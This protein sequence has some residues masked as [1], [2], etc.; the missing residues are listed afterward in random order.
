VS[1]LSNRWTEEVPAQT[2]DDVSLPTSELDGRELPRGPAEPES[3]RIGGTIDGVHRIRGV[4]G[5]G[6]MGTVYLAH[7]EQLQRDVAVKLIHENELAD[8]PVVERFLAE[9][10]AM[11]RVQ[12]PNVVTI[13]AFGS[14]R[15]RPYLVM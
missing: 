3:Q 15:S 14:H 8:A 2:L 12:H 9:A 13:H 7:D 10:R 1:A 11:A 4:L 6:A 5:S